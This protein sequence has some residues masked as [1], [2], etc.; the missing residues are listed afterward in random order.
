MVDEYKKL[1]ELL[2]QVNPDVMRKAKQGAA[3]FSL[4]GAAE[5]ALAELREQLG[6]EK[7]EDSETALDVPSEKTPVTA[8]SSKAL[9][10]YS[11]TSDLNQKPSIDIDKA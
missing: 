4:R 11:T 5:D 1:H 6:Y 7:L 2:K 10:S 9:N 3:L 8:P